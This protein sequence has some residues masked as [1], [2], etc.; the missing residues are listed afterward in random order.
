MIAAIALA[1]SVPVLLVAS[2]LVGLLGA[3]GNVTELSCLQRIVPGPLLGRVF[4]I[5]EVGS[6]A[7]IPL[8]QIAGGILIVTV[9]IRVTYLLSGFGTAAIALLLLV[10]RDVRALGYPPR[11]ATPSSR[12]AVLASSDPKSAGA[13]E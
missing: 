12:P 9:G 10:S 4:S 2:P 7:V 5:D 8:G 3:V 6:F 13:S 11:G 1:P